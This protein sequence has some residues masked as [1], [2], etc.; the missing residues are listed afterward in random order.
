[1]IGLNKQAS[2]VCKSLFVLLKVKRFELKL[3]G[4]GSFESKYIRN[5]H[6]G[7]ET[8]H[9]ERKHICSKA[10]IKLNTNGNIFMKQT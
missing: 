9:I 5:N 6:N 10:E 7:N 8:P 4:S 3:T 2:K 1:M